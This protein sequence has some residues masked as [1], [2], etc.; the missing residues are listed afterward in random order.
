[1]MLEEI[2]FDDFHTFSA[3]YDN[4]FEK[5]EEKYINLYKNNIKNMHFVHPNVESLIEDLDDFV[6]AMVEPVTTSSEYAEFKVMQLAQNHCTVLLNGQ[7]VDEIFGGYKYI[8]GPYLIELMHQKKYFTFFKEWAKYYQVNKDLQAY[9]SF[10]FHLLSNKW[11]NTLIKKNRKYINSDFNE[12][13]KLSSELSNELY[14]A[15]SLLQSSLKHFEHKFEHHLIWADK[16]GM[17]FSLETRFPYLDHR[18]VEYS[19]S[20]PADDKIKNGIP[21]YLFKKSMK[22]YLPKQIYNR[23]DKIGYE[24]PEKIGFSTESSK[25]YLMILLSQIIH[26]YQ[27]ILT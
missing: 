12:R 19:L 26:H 2:K 10:L 9:K 17:W 8:F 3:V 24:T 20:L 15:N 5:N 1:M 25:I 4:S 13:S 11:K 16:S 27:T 23:T 18:F 22:K 14:N 7:G 6:T 21:K